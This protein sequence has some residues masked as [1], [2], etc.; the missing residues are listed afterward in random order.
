MCFRELTWARVIGFPLRVK[1]MWGWVQCVWER[2]LHEKSFSENKVGLLMEE[3]SH[4]Q[5]HFCR[6]RSKENSK[7][8]QIG[9]NLSCC[10]FFSLTGLYMLLGKKWAMRRLCPPLTFPLHLLQFS[11]AVFYM[12]QQAAVFLSKL[13]YKIS[14]PPRPSKDMA[15]MQSSLLLLRIVG[16]GASSGLN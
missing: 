10:L 9:A 4:K 12:K 6:Y 13:F 3:H 11:Y 15:L 8:L 7:P 5:Q 2:D 14:S 16:R 1:C